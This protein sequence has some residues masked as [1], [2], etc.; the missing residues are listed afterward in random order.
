[1]WEVFIYNFSLQ[2]DFDNWRRKLWEP[3]CQAFG[4]EFKSVA[5]VIKPTY[6]LKEHDSAAKQ[7]TLVTWNTK[8][9]NRKY[10]F[11]GRHYY[12]IIH[13]SIIVLLM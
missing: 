5:K 12:L 13:E 11:I 8:G 10:V 3:V 9:I 7:S 1:M 6:I 4:I 2:E